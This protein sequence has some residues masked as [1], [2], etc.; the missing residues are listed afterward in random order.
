MQASLARMNQS[1]EA[2]VYCI[3][4]AQVNARR[5]ILGSGGQ[6][7]E[8][9]REFIVLLEDAIWQPDIA[10]S[11]ARYQLIVDEAKVRLKTRCLIRNMAHT[12]QSCPEHSK[13]RWI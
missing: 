12:F 3:L 9:Q 8:T 13:Y 6:A 2:F 7:K 4:R 5:S 1:I 10:K 11:V